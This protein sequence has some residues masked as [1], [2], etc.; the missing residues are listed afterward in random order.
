M[1]GAAP[2]DV[3]NGRAFRA[4]LEDGR[5]L[6]GRGQVAVGDAGLGLA[7]VKSG[8]PRSCR[9]TALLPPAV[10]SPAPPRTS[11]AQRCGPRSRPHTQLPRFVSRGLWIVE[12]MFLSIGFITKPDHIRHHV[13]FFSEG[14]ALK[15][16]KSS[17][18]LTFLC[19]INLL[20]NPTSSLQNL[21]Q[22]P[23]PHP[24]DRRH[25]RV[26]LSSPAF[27]GPDLIITSHLLKAGLG[28][29]WS[30]LK[31]IRVPSCLLSRYRPGELPSGPEPFSCVYLL[32]FNLGFLI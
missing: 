18:P 15:S 17:L 31:N 26:C 19:L 7:V 12:T 24:G 6:T 9:V 32:C 20:R 3:S 2:K 4:G 13:F 29:L 30:Q 21:K 11:G 10:A 16:E 25:D 5:G 28:L 1:E 23:R 27:P 22:G 14:V 8:F